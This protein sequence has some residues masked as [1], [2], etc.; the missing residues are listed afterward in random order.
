MLLPGEKVALAPPGSF[1]DKMDISKVNVSN[2]VECRS[3]YNF[4]KR[5]GLLAHIK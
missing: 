4:L 3:S 5:K 1:E 2:R